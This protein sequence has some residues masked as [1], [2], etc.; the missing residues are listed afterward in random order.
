M[1]KK[2]LVLALLATL[3]ACSSKGQVREDTLPDPAR[4]YPAGGTYVNLDNL[5]QYAPGMNKDQL[6]TLLGTPHF[7]EGLWGVREWNYLFNFRRSVGAAPIQCQF[8]V[9]FNADGSSSGQ[10]WKPESCAALLEPP[11]A[12]APPA[13]P[14]AAA[15][16]RIS[17]D[18]LFAFDSATLAEGGRARLA[19]VV[20]GLGPRVNDV[21]LVVIGY[22][23]R[24]GSDAYNRTLSQRRADAVREYLVQQGVPANAIRAEGRG[25]TEPLVDCSGSSG[26]ALISCLAPNRRVEI[27]GIG[28]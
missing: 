24:I 3:T 2:W 16:L 13:P 14:A 15:P 4:A 6:Q 22:T 28:G 25:N 7:N 23:D 19:E 9:R 27:S 8:Q 21:N 20:S 26:T 11:P 10:A 18:A 1:D 17:A 12:P 5:R